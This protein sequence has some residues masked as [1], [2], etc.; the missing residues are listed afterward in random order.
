MKALLMTITLMAVWTYSNGQSKFFPLTKG[1]TWVY[2]FGK[3]IYGGTPYEYYTNKV[4]ILDITETIGGIEYFVSETS[5]G[6]GNDNRTTITTYFRFG[7]D[8]SIISK[9]DK[10][11][12]ELV[13][14][15][16]D[17]N[18]GDTY[19]SRQGGTSKVINLNASIK[20]ENKTYTGCL[21]IE[22]IEN[23]TI[24]RTYYQKHIGMVAT[25]I[26]SDGK[27]RI[28]TYLVSK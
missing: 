20:T 4:K 15:K 9:S 8:G 13:A 23:Q 3:E 6:S 10:T 22:T 19:E 26:V 17:P 27:E 24:F 28:F 25:T 7:K 5:T 16:K 18:V 12:K 11:A 21:L 14:M 2:S 1:T